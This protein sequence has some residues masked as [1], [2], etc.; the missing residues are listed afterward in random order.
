M[1]TFLWLALLVVFLVVEAATITVVSIWFA[2]GA[3]AA[4]VTSFF[5]E[6]LWIQIAVFVAVSGLMLLLLRPLVHKF[7]TPHRTATNADRLL[8]MEGTV[9]QDIAGSQPQGQI[10]VAGAVWT[11]RSE[12]G[13]PIPL[14]TAVCILRIEGVTAIVAPSH[15]TEEERS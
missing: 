7:I 8:G 5:V 2:I 11:A 1:L 13:D 4:M 6:S 14:G 10:T 15:K 12:T 9:T 3:A